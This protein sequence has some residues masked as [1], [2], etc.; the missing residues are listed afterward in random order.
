LVGFLQHDP[1]TME[2]ETAALTGK[3]GYEDIVL[4]YQAETAAYGGQFMKARE[5]TRR[6]V[7]SALR[8]DEK[9]VAAN[10]QA[11]AALREALAGNLGLAKPQAQ[12][13]LALSKG[14]DT[15]GIAALALAL[16]GDT[17]QAAHLADDLDKRFPQDTLAQSDHLPTIR[18]AA[19]L[20]N[21][22]AAADA[23]Q[24][25]KLLAAAAPYEL[26]AL[27]QPLNFALYPVYVRGQAYLAAHQGGAA[28]AEFE[29]ILGHPG[30]V[31]N[32]PIGALAHLQLGRAYALSGDAAKGKTAY[33]D[34]LAL[35]KDADLDIPILKQAKAEYAKLM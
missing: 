33:Q 34:F 31:L 23:G 3:P 17:A 16:A 15:Q 21:G 2:R 4:H 29:K 10:Y 32:Q 8:T 13:A 20:Q 6:A 12:A 7:A 1:V 19:A 11:A 26:G 35:W 14:R 9:E 22:G 27:T 25:V 18:A 24:A 5:L 28:V 30:V